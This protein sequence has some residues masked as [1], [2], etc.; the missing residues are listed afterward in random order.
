MKRLHQGETA[1]GCAPGA[2]RGS[3]GIG[4]NLQHRD[5]GEQ[6]MVAALLFSAYQ[7]QNYR[8][9]DMLLEHELFTERL[10]R[11]QQTQ[12]EAAAARS[13]APYRVG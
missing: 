4:R 2:E 11:S 7:E 9:R 12:T 8:L 1:R 10:I 3:E 13:K 6:Y 5:T